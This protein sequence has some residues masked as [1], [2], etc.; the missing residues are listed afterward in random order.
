[1][2]FSWFSLDIKGGHVGASEQRKALMSVSQT[3]MKKLSSIHMQTFSF[4]SAETHG[5]G[6]DER[7]PAIHAP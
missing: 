6:S 1:M 5:S 7:K 2:R 3:I 4:V